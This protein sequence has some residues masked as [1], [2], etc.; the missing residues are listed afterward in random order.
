MSQPREKYP[1][2]AILGSELLGP[3]LALLIQKMEERPSDDPNT[4]FVCQGAALHFAQCFGVSEGENRKGHHA[5]S[6]CILRQ[7]I[8]SL[9]IIELGLCQDINWANSIL[10]GW[11]ENTISLGKIR[12]ELEQNVWAIYG[13]GLWSESWSEFFAE[14]AGAVQPYA[15]YT[16]DL[17]AWQLEILKSPEASRT[18]DGGI[19]LYAKIG[20]DT[21]DADKATRITLYQIVLIW[22]VGRVVMANA[23][24]SRLQ[25]DKI[26][27]LGVALSKAPELGLGRL[28]WREQFWATEFNEPF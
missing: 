19:V 2:W 23:R 1:D 25:E 9:S 10:S 11:H 6:M 8:E 5:V 3:V 13:K 27:K 4:N 7:C 18:E 15:H 12:K 17:Q 26:L 16:R 22:A 28:S 24:D 14:L 21:Y 20:P